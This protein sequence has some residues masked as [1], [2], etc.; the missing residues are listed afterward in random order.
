MADL[1]KDELLA[2]HN[3]YKEYNS[4]WKLF[5]LTYESGY[6]LIEYALTRHARETY[7]NWQERLAEGYNFNFGKSIVDI[8]SFYLTEKDVIRKL[9]AL[10]DDPIWELFSKDA[11]LQGT[12]YNV[13][14]DDIQKIA[15]TY[16]SSG[17]LV[18]KP[19][20]ENLTVQQDIN[21]GIYPY[22]CVYSLPNIFNWKFKRN[23]T[24]HRWELVFL[25]LMEIDGNHLVWY[26]DRWEQ[27]TVT[28]NASGAVTKVEKIDS[29]INALKEIPF[30]WMVNLKNRKHPEIGASDL[31]DISRIV[32]SI[33]RDL[34]CGQEIMKFA[35]FPIR[36]QPMETDTGDAGGEDEIETGPRAVEEF[37][38]T[39]GEGG[40]PDWMPTE[41][42]EPIEAIL[43]WIDRKS[44][45][46]YRVAHLS[47]VHGQRKSNNEV[48]SGMALRY[49]FQQLN[50]VM[51][52]KSVNQT[53]A[54]LNA[55]RYWLMWQEKK[56]VFDSIIIKRSTEFSIDDLS[57]ALDN[58]ITG[59]TSVL[60]KTFRMR[61]QEKIV[62]HVL[63]DLNPKDQK[64]I[65]NEIKTNTPE[66]LEI[67]LKKPTKTR[68]ALESRADHSENG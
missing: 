11:D 57:I 66:K 33:I 64:S 17:I 25:N 5:D 14:I 7:G 68:T 58:A 21:D 48:A 51:N 12:N 4:D 63:P 6:P 60:S 59:M 40:K 43:K 39:L 37:D 2:K 44:D 10:K 22:Y 52:A 65:F 31:V 46:V 28:K 50:A 16:G 61:V 8:F 53:E 34:S 26:P 62:D 9:A 30:V 36:R 29:G 38:P 24:T 19:G 13:L 41:I 20:T 45:E 23:K 55:L 56:D 42:L 47:G 35:G 54:E 67:D 27:Y 15:S 1:N 32:T 18:T 3:L 49:E